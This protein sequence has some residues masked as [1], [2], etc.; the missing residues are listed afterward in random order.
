[1]DI[2]NMPTGI[3]ELI[4]EN[5][6][7]QEGYFTFL[8]NEADLQNVVG[9]IDQ[10]SRTAD[11]ESSWSRSESVVTFLRRERNRP[12][13]ELRD[14][15][16]A[17]QE[18]QQPDAD[19]ADMAEEDVEDDL[20]LTYSVIN[21]DPENEPPD[22]SEMEKIEAI[23]SGMQN[24]I[25]NDSKTVSDK[26]REFNRKWT[27]VI[28]LKRSI[29]D[30]TESIKSNPIIGSLIEQANELESLDNL[31][32]SVKFSDGKVVVKTKRLVTSQRIDGHIREIGRMK[33]TISLSPFVGSITKN[34][35][36]IQIKNLDRRVSYGRNSEWECGHVPTNSLPCW[37]TAFDQMFHAYESR[38]LHALVEVLI[39]FVTSPNP[40][41]SYGTHIKGFPNYQTDGG[42][43]EAQ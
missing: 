29:D 41:D 27:E 18:T 32:E 36:P 21:V 23:A 24:S 19:F 28:T 39:R 3:F 10:F 35:D 13:P 17:E 4:S 16:H 2:N 38:D 9:M 20:P 6:T 8:I 14:P 25:S 26:L 33:F 7:V 11:Y 30:M 37:G 42:S 5:P 22:L 12:T 31:V 34:E 15:D 40:E 43:N 1:M